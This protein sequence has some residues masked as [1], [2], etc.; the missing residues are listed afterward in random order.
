MPQSSKARVGRSGMPP[1]QIA[2]SLTARFRRSSLGRTQDVNQNR[3]SLAPCL[4]NDP[5]HFLD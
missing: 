3:H 5:L 1:A 4:L 2:A